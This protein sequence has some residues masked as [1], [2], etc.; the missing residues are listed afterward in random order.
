[1]ADSHIH[2]PCDGRG[3]RAVFV[4]GQRVE[5]VTYADTRRGLIRYVRYP[6]TVNGRGEVIESTRRGKVEV[7]SLDD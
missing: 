4:N 7:R 6:L 5:R 2:T 1:M 3:P